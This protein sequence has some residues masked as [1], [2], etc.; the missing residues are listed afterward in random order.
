MAYSHELIGNIGVNDESNGRGPLN[1]G[2]GVDTLGR[3]TITFGTSYALR[4][5]VED[6]DQLR[7][8]LYE[9]SRRLDAL[10]YERELEEAMGYRNVKQ[11]SA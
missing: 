10:R 1:V 6:V 7:D 5:P 8:M 11:E 2:I 3:C 9:A 4:I